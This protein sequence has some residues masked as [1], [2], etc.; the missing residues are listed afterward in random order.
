MH[1]LRVLDQE[2]Q[3]LRS[4]VALTVLES[5]G[6][7]M[8]RLAVPEIMLTSRK[9]V[10]LV[11]TVLTVLLMRELRKTRHSHVQLFEREVFAGR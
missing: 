4:T 5:D 6:D 11:V 2:A 1:N 9:S 8:E 10:E 7:V 3:E